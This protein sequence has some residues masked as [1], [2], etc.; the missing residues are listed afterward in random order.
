[1]ATDVRGIDVK[2]LPE[3]KAPPLQHELRIA[4]DAS[5]GVIALLLALGA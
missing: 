4:I 5:Y 1:M 3:Q 2:A